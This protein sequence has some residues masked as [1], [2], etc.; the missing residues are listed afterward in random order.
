MKMKKIVRKMYKAILE[1]NQKKEKKLWMKTLKK[2]L[3]H[4]KTHAIR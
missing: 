1:K 3:R 2:S 4:K